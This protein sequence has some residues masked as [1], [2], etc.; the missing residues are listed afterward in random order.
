MSRRRMQRSMSLRGPISKDY[1]RRRFARSSRK[2]LKFI[3]ALLDSFVE[4]YEN[5]AE[6][7]RLRLLDPQNAVIDSDISK[8]EE[9]VR[10][11]EWNGG[12]YPYE[13]VQS[14]LSV[15]SDDDDD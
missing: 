11:V 4:R 2:D 8:M 6:I 5:G 7:E 3:D 10:L 15:L 1:Y 13:V 12:Y 9:V 14:V